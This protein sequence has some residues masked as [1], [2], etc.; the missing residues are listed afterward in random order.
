MLPERAPWLDSHIH[1]FCTFPAGKHDD[2]IDA[3][4]LALNAFVRARTEKRQSIEVAR[5]TDLGEI[6]QFALVSFGARGDLPHT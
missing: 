5:S 4:Q 2:Q 6:V 3:T 1:E